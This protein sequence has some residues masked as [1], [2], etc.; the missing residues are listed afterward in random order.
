MASVRDFGAKGDGSSDDT[1]AIRHAVRQGDGHIEFP[2][3]DYRLTGTISIPLDKVGRIS[4]SG[5]G[6]PARFVMCQSG[7]AL[8]LIGSHRRTAD[9]EHFLPG[10][11]QRERMP[12]VSGL[13]IVGEHP[14][15]D[16]I[17][18]D[19][20]MQA[21]LVALL[22]RRCRYGI[23]LT[24]RNRNVIVSDC[25]I[26]HGR[27]IGL[28]L[29]HV[30]LHQ[31]NVTGNHIS[32]CPRGGVV[33]TGSEVRNIQ[34]VGNDIE[35]NFDASAERSADLWFDCSS[36]GSIREGT[37]VGNTIQAKLSPG[38]AN[39]RFTGAPN[40]SNQIGMITINGN[41]IG[42]QTALI[43]LQSCRGVV[44]SG[45]CLYN[46]FHDALHAQ[47]CEHLVLS[48]NS[49]DHNSDYQGKSTDA[50]RFH[51]CRTVTL[52]GTVVQHTRD[53]VVAVPAT[54]DFDNCENVGI[55]GCQLLN[56]RERGV[57]FVN[58][59]MVRVT[60]N[61]IR[62]RREGFRASIAVESSLGVVVANNLLARGSEGIIAGRAGDPA[63]IRD[64]LT[65]D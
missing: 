4:V 55:S 8:H 56:M 51:H 41:L 45:N 14:Q 25:H 60:D 64:N 30:N 35:Y 47:R 39:V 62:G 59:R 15:A 37:I 16:G 34:I 1:E 20:T 28:F 49:I 13:E 44:V 32:Y 40:D 54:V 6:G 5:Q 19:G 43:D 65:I 23:H 63:L 52:T 18:L 31:I 27:A 11:W 22:I 29:D 61:T 38:G 9:P 3:G 53:P 42:S 2:R 7:P 17:R 36:G 24:N 58:C 12:A 33:V 10:I 48:G 57:R 50:L 26:Y 21:S 46:G